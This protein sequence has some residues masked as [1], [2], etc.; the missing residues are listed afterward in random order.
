MA[1]ILYPVTGGALYA[2]QSHGLL[3]IWLLQDIVYCKYNI[4][5]D[6]IYSHITGYEAFTTITTRIY[7][8]TFVLL[9]IK[10]FKFEVYF[11]FTRCC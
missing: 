2:R 5:E 7:H 6:I 9:I 1:Y 8:V 10:L 4:I 11:T 3:F